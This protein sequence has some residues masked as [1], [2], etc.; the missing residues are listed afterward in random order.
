MNTSGTVSA[1]VRPAARRTSPGDSPWGRLSPRRSGGR[2]RSLSDLGTVAYGAGAALLV[3]AMTVGVAALI[4]AGLGKQTLAV[5][6]LLFAVVLIFL[7]WQRG[8]YAALVY[9]PFSGL[10][11]LAFHPWAGALLIKDIAFILPAYLA[12]GAT[13]LN[14][15]L[16]LG[17]RRPHRL[18]LVSLVTLAVMVVARMAGPEVQSWLMAAIGAKIWLFYLPL[19]FLGQQLVDSRAQ[20]ASLFRVLAVT[21]IIP[22]GL[23]IVQ[24]LLVPVV[25]YQA[26]MEGVYGE[27]AVHVTQGFVEFEV[28]A[29]AIRR[30]PSTFTYVTQYFTYTLASIAVGY[31]VW[32][33]DPSPGWRAA[34]AMIT[35]LVSI[36]SLVSGARSA[37]VLVPFLWAMILLLDRALGTIVR[38]GPVALL[39]ALVVL[40]MLGT[41]TSS[42]Y[43]HISARFGHEY[44]SPGMVGEAF[45][46]GGMWGLGT[47][48]NTGAARYGMADSGALVTL[49]SYYAKSIYELGLLGFLA[50]IGLFVSVL[51]TGYASHRAVADRRVRACTAALLGFV[52]LII[53]SGFK[54]WMIELDPANVYFWLFSG[55]IV[56]LAVLGE[57]G[58]GDGVRPPGAGGLA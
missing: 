33:G 35:V 48:T 57:S 11:T 14:G 10:V 42:L 58:D 21:A 20:A 25:G 47:G 8:L 45:T 29:G 1:V 37:F 34:G 46:R 24:V 32:R 41:D 26:L 30:I 38:H 27:N 53:L 28:G 7:R 56:K 55:L 54:G 4:S 2:A 5:V 23:G 31:C 15:S 13:A 3:L 44:A 52:A 18:F 49:E 17:E 36:A 43:T 12:S 22:C 40:V 51:W 16:R 50:V 6:A 19:Y 39:L 9:L